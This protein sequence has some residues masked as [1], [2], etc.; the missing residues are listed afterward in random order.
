MARH[1][2][3]DV[4]RACEAAME[5]FWR[6]GYE[7]TSV[8]D[9]VAHLGIAKASLYATFGTKHDLY[10]TALGR[11]VERTNDQIVRDLSGPGSALAAVQRL[12]DRFADEILADEQR[13]GCM[14]VNAATER[15]PGDH[16]AVRLVEHSWDVLETSLTMA[17]SRALAEGEL[18]AGSDPRALARMLMALLQGMRVFGK[19][20]YAAD[21][22]RDAA[23]EARR[24]VQPDSGTNGLEMRGD[25]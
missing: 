12:V 4:G 3:F 8:N 2:E 18:R 19:S 1:R 13:R 21:R 17:L 23:R 11:Y 16:S 6:K 25:G 20:E 24:V 5:L 9:L 22:V 15:L 10:T 14:V 7:A